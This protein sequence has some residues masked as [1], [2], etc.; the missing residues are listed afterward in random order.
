MRKTPLS[1]EQAS[2]LY[3]E[4]LRTLTPEDGELLEMVFAYEYLFADM[5]LEAN[6]VVHD[7][8]AYQIETDDGKFMEASDDHYLSLDSQ[9]WRFY[10]RNLNST[11]AI[12]IT[13]RNERKVVVDR[14]HKNSTPTIL[15]EMIHAHEAVISQLYPFYRDTLILCLY[16]D[17]EQKISDLYE[18]IIDHTHEI[19][20][21]EITNA[22]G[23]HDVLFFLKSL[24]LDLKL[25]FKLG[26]VCGYGRDL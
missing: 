22:G 8:V 3:H 7:F 10:V 19:F 12:G 5:C 17:L 26:T 13:Y 9:K 1:D 14:K 18:R 25:G 20:G 16:R 2:K 24:D 6:S 4:Y 11:K 15:H 23:S 21:T